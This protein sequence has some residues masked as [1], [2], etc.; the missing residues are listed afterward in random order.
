MGSIPCRS[1]SAGCSHA[2]PAV[3]VGQCRHGLLYGWRADRCSSFQPGDAERPLF[4]YQNANRTVRKGIRKDRNRFFAQ[5]GRTEVTD[6]KVISTNKLSTLTEV[7][8]YEETVSHVKEEHPEVPIELPCIAT[9]VEG[10]IQNP[11]RIES[12]YGNSVIFVDTGTTNAKGEPLR[13]PVKHIAGTSGRVRT[14][15]FASSNSTP[16]V[17][18]RRDE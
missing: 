18:W 5:V 10:A 17:I 7:R 13:V 8:F 1:A 14:V 2:L 11:S 12:S 16:S 15:Y 4:G 3:C 9:A 6:Y